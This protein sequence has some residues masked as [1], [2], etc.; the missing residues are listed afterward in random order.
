MRSRTPSTKA[1]GV[2]CQPH[3]AVDR[4]RGEHRDA[5]A[6]AAATAAGVGAL[7]GEHGRARE[8]RDR[9]E[10]K[11]P[12]ADQRGALRQHERPGERVAE[13]VPR[14][15]GE[16]M[17]AQP[18]GERSARPRARASASGR[19]STAARASA[20]P[21]AGEDREPGRQRRDRE[22]QQPAE[23]LGVDQ[24]RVADPVEPGDEIAEAEPPAGDRRPPDAA[25]S[26]PP[27]RRRSARPGPERSGTAPARD[28]T[29]PAPAPRPRRRER[30]RGAPPAPGQHDRVSEAREGHGCAA[31][32]RDRSAAS[33]AEASGVRAI[34]GSQ[35]RVRPASFGARPDSSRR[36]GVS[37]LALGGDPCRDGS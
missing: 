19:A 37:R 16:E 20:K 23:G 13:R 22:R 9:D 18:F 36:G 10:G 21:S 15:S 5:D 2:A 24:E 27:P 25:A 7:V 1:V 11:T 14:K 29:A 33:F 17:A 32:L 30:D 12:H 26:G 35:R 28:R 31:G 4:E 6:R 34:R 8:H 3:R